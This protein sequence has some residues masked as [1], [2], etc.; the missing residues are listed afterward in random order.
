MSAAGD[1]K[2]GSARRR[3]NILAADARR[4]DRNEAYK[5]AAA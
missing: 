3:A 1:V 4:E 5:E 2:A